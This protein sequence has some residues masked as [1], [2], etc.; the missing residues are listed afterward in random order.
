ML[1]KALH[2]AFEIDYNI[3]ISIDKYW[4]KH[5]VS[6]KWIKSTKYN[7]VSGCGARITEP[8]P[9]EHV[10]QSNRNSIAGL[11]EWIDSEL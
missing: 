8:N 11:S 3:G 1:G 7:K 10:R 9:G 2:E 5:F 6:V 4:N